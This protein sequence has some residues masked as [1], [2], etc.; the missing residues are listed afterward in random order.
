MTVA[1][2]SATHTGTALWYLTR[3]TGLVSLVLLSGTVI[4]GIIS[5]VGWT[6]QQW[7]RFVSQTM[8]RNVS[9]FCL[10]LIGLHVVTTV[11]DGYVPIGYRDAF[12]PFLTQYRP[13]WVGLGAL[14]FDILL[15][16][17]ITS[18]LRRRIG[19]RAWRGVH[20]MA[21]MCWPIAVLH[22]LGSG[23][24]ARLS[25]MILLEV[26]CIVSVV[27]SV[28]WRI[29]E[30][31]RMPSG[32]RLA[33]AGATTALVVGIGAFA[34]SGP[35]QPGWSRRAGTSPVL[36]AQLNARF[37]SKSAAAASGTSG[38]PTAP[39][40]VVPTST[41]GLPPLPFT[42]NV[43]GTIATSSPNSAGDVE[44]QLTMQV[45]GAS[46]PLQVQLIGRAV[47]G[48]VAMS[49]SKV[50]F[51]NER[52]AVTALDGSSI[53]ATVRGPM[54]TVNLVIQLSIDQSSGTFSGS[55]SGS[56]GANQ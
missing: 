13:L 41:N 29:V 19:V 46:A 51:G 49:T 4:L 52:G 22:G 24:D 38:S 50:S 16:V 6:A 54:G 25:I 12:I 47:N 18:G 33:A 40:T 28:L 8:H 44:V 43:T 7:P 39:T 32:R 10:A 11:A 20:Y 5:S 9:L 34:L 2:A 14:A 36:L 56:S 55:V 37:A 45:Q 27:G 35:L 53:G 15:A 17:G 21:Y 30:A 1:V 23:T 42:E 48:G 26:I 3:A 31:R